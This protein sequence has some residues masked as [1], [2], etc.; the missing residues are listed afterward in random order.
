MEGPL[1]RLLLPKYLHPVTALPQ[2][3]AH[4][5]ETPIP[6]CDEPRKTPDRTTRKEANSRKSPEQDPYRTPTRKARYGKKA[7]EGCYPAKQGLKRRRELHR[8]SV[9]QFRR[10]SSSRT[11]I[12]TSP[13]QPGSRVQVRIEFQSRSNG[14]SAVQVIKNSSLASARRYRQRHSNIRNRQICAFSNSSA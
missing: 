3:I 10:V 8:G 9:Q 2:G 1:P 11:R 14:R 12:E 4:E 5:R 6:A 13:D 7:V